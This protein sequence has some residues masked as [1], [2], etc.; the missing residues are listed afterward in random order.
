MTLA[1]KLN[2]LSVYKNNTLLIYKHFIYWQCFILLRSEQE[3]LK[4]I[5]LSNTHF[6]RV[7]ISA[8]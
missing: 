2:L 5:P 3:N 4:I 7:G 1:K 6:L 8:V